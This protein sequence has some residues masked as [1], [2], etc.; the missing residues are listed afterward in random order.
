MVALSI[1]RATAEPEFHYWGP[2]QPIWDYARK[3]GSKMTGQW[4]LSLAILSGFASN[5]LDGYERK[6]A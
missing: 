4:T 3:R 2:A 6:D 5:E 1:G